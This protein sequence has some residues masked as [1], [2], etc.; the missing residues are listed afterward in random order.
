MIYFDQSY[1]KKKIGKADFFCGI[2]K[3]EFEINIYFVI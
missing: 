1:Y 2:D 3:F